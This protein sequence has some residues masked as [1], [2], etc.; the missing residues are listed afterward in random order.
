[1]QMA[2]H[3]H[4]Q[5]RSRDQLRR[6]APLEPIAIDGYVEG[7]QEGW[8]KSEGNWPNIQQYLDDLSQANLKVRAA[9]GLRIFSLQKTCMTRMHR[10]KDKVQ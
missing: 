3:F 5:F 6:M 10:M 7:K 4:N 9:Y 1:M 2:V 8:L